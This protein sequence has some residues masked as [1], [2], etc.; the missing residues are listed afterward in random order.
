VVPGP[1]FDQRV[2]FVA[3]T[4]FGAVI[5]VLYAPSFEGE[6]QMIGIA[7]GSVPAALATIAVMSLGCGYMCMKLRL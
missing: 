7:P 6:L 5:G 1:S 4:I 2:R 3:G